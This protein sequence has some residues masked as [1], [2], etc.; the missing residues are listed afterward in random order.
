MNN[1]RLIGIILMVVG[2]GIA[3]LAGGWI[4]SQVS[5]GTLESGGAVLGAGL[6]FIPVAALVGFGLYLFT[7]GGAEAK[8]HSAV[9]QQR[10][11]LDI[12]KSKGQVS[13]HDVAM[14]LGVSVDVVRDF[15]H[16]LVGLQVFSGYINW[17]EGVLYSSEASQL[18]N[19][20]K[21]KNCGGEIT[22]AGKG[23]VA[24]RFCGTEYFLS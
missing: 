4:A 20:D 21:C 10:R 15:V 1:N 22:L 13:V 7:K 16:Q 14:E 6:A 17:D 2:L 5:G 3:V 9:Q 19:L 24:C 12:V 8:T 11:I 18:R 23:V